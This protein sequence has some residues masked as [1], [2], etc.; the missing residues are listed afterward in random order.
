MLWATGQFFTKVLRLNKQI[1]SEALVEIYRNITFCI[2][3]QEVDN[4]TQIQYW[5]RE[6]P[7][8]LTTH[9]QLHFDVNNTGTNGCVKLP[10]IKKV[11]RYHRIDRLIE[12]I[13]NMPNLSRL[14]IILSM[15]DGG[16]YTWTTEMMEKRFRPLF[17][18]RRWIRNGIKIHVAVHSDSRPINNESHLV[19]AIG[20]LKGFLEEDGFDIMRWAPDHHDHRE[21]WQI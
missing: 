17:Y 1:Y 11:L 14:D 4:L 10:E 21:V 12:M 8:Q 13:N 2:S 5:L 9:L 19:S 16:M 20:M 7:V 6:H 15:L 3:A 18:I